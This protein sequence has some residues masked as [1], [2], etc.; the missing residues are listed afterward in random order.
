M[1]E[2]GGSRPDRDPAEPG[3]ESV[4]T[5]LKSLVTQ[6]GTMRR[7]VEDIAA[8]IPAEHIEAHDRLRRDVDRLRRLHDQAPAPFWWGD[9]AEKDRQQREHDIRQWVT[10]VLGDFPVGELLAEKPCWWQHV[11]LRHH[12]IA[13]WV[14]WLGAYRAPDR[15]YSDPDDWITKRLPTFAKADELKRLGAPGEPCDDHPP[16]RPVG[17]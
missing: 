15:R 11:A 8:T 17:L 2:D 5:R 13:L 7:R 3:R 9:V 16:P 6:V 4:A 12:V 1:T 10:T 14:A